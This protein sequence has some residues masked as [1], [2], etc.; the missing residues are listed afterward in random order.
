ME[1]R[2]LL[3]IFLSFLVL[4]V[5]QAL[6]VKPIP[7]PAETAATPNA[8]APA[9]KGGPAPAPTSAP[10]TA[11][12]RTQPAATAL[13]GDTAEREVR[14]ETRD[15][16]A[17]FTNRGARLKSWRLKHFLDQKNEPLELVA[18]EL[19]GT[20]PLPFSLT[21]NDAAVTT[22]LNNALYTVSGEPA[23]AA[24]SPTDLRFE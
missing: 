15:V 8:A 9:T 23:A 13:V 5:Y 3:A 24:S 6:V 19:A 12:A 2:V 1:R 14:V 4:Y 20:Q 17:V 18:T 11:A 10:G 7:K 16:I 21:V 22:T